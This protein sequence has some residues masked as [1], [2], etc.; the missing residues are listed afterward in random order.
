MIFDARTIAAAT[1][2]EL[3][4]DGP[5]GPVG[6]DSRRVAPGSWFVALT[7]DKFDGHNFLGVA[8]ASGAAGAIVSKAPERW[9]AGLVLVPDTLVA[10]QGLARFARDSFGGPVVGITGSAGKTSTR[11]MIVDALQ[12]LGIVHHTQGNLNNHIGLPLTLCHLPP[13]P[14]PWLWRWA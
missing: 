13:M 6:T 4:H 12:S 8:G 14:M 3:L 9:P 10:L 1:D 2:G 5:A 7:G 11:V